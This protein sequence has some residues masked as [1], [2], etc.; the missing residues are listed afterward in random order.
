MKCHSIYYLIGVDKCNKES[1]EHFE[2]CIRHLIQWT[3][4]GWRRK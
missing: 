3:K 2:L 1:L 4:E